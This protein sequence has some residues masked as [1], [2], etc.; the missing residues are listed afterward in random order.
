MNS[1]IGVLTGGL[2]CLAFT[3]AFATL[4][5]PHKDPI[6]TKYI[7]YDDYGNPQDST[8]SLKEVC[9]GGVC[10]QGFLGCDIT[11]DVLLGKDDHKELF[12]FFTDMF[13]SVDNRPGQGRCLTLGCKD[14]VFEAAAALGTPGLAP[15]LVDQITGDKL[16]KLNCRDKQYLYRALWYLGD[17]TTADAM[18]AGYKD[19]RCTNNHFNYTAPLIHQWKL[20]EEQYDRIAELCVDTI[21]TESIKNADDSFEACHIYFAKRGKVSEDGLDHIRMK[22]NNEWALRALAVLDAKGSKK[23]F[24]GLLK[25]AETKKK[26]KTVWRGGRTDQVIAGVALHMAGDRKGKAAL[27]YWLG[28]KNKQ[29]NDSQGF[30]K[31]FLEVAPFW[32]TSTKNKLRKPLERAFAK[33]KKLADADEGIANAVRRAAVGLAQL[34]SNKG[35]GVIVDGLKDRSGST[36]EEV[37]KGLGGATNLSTARRQGTATLAFG[38]G[39]LGTKDGQK[40]IK[41]LQKALKLAKPRQREPFARA[42][43]VIK[44]QMDAAGL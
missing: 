38:K 3:V 37:A 6:C 28:T 30:E 33:A 31:V 8:G 36:R 44:A 24:A 26:K 41:A 4:P 9:G 15:L 34:G 13:H 22:S 17:K 21:Y 29:L 40:L 35:I 5:E 2:V 1:F 12:P 16:S 7:T 11:K 18:I 19:L 39:L 32:P 25:K 20:S 10:R 23:L 14:D 42:I 43:I 27:K